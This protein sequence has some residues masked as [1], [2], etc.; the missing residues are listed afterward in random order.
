MVSALLSSGMGEAAFVPR[1]EGRARLGSSTAVEAFYERPRKAEVGPAKHYGAG[2]EHR[3]GPWIVGG[4]VRRYTTSEWTQTPV[5]VM[6]GAVL[7][8]G[9][10]AR[11]EQ[12]LKGRKATSL[13]VRTR[14]LKNWEQEG[15]LYR[16]GEAGVVN[17][18]PAGWG[19]TVKF[20]LVLGR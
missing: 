13:H 11:V 20:S 1:V 14:F 9:V 3:I 6:A 17:S 5:R 4:S 15:G 2:I 12:Q 10:E 16:Y 8:P 19:F 18:G 7:I